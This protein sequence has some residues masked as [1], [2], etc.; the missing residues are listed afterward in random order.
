MEYEITYGRTEVG[1]ILKW[2]SQRALVHMGITHF[3][4]TKLV[5]GCV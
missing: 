2:F 5:G 1:I 3:V 4:Q